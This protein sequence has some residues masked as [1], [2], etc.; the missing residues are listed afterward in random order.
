MTLFIGYQ[1]ISFLDAERF[2]DIVMLYFHSE[3]CI[4]RAGR[5]STGVARIARLL[6]VRADICKCRSTQISKKYIF[7]N[8]SYIG[9]F[10]HIVSPDDDL[11]RVSEA[12]VPSSAARIPSSQCDLAAM[13]TSCRPKLVTPITAAAPEKPLTNANVSSQRVARA[14]T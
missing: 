14:P 11:A 3:I 2:S 13:I 9:A 7:I 6:R 1:N 10:S 5:P 12:Y 8:I 4:G